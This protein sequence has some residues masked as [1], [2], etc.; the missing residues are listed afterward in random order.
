MD[1]AGDVQE[2]GVSGHEVLSLHV[3]ALG[4]GGLFGLA[5]GFRRAFQKTTKKGVL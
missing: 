1:G 2:G 5:F 4:E 3:I